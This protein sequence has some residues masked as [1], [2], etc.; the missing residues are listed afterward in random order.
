V[1]DQLLARQGV[2]LDEVVAQFKAAR[3]NRRPPAKSP[4]LGQRVRQLLIEHAPNVKFFAPDVTYADARKYLPALLEKRG[5]NGAV[6][7]T[8][9][10]TLESVVRP[11]NFTCMRSCN[12]RPFR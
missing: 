6:A 5:V 9:L 4:R 1:L 10:D 2:D 12:T 8:V 11:S 7:L 3:P